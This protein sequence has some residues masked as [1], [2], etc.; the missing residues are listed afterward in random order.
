MKNRALRIKDTRESPLSK[1]RR[2]PGRGTKGDKDA[3]GEEHG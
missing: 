1:Q 3:C 2:G